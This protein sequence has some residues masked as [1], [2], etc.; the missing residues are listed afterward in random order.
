MNFAIS[1][2][3][4]RRNLDSGP[5]LTRLMALKWDLKLFKSLLYLLVSLSFNQW[6]AVVAAGYFAD[7]AFIITT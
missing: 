4:W 7:F 5:K 1:T 6:L 3:E 2:G